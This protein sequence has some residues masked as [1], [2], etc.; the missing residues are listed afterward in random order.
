MQVQFYIPHPLLQ[1]FINCIMIVHA[2]VEADGSSNI[3]IYPPTPQ[4]S[5][6]F[7]INDQVK[8]RKE[9]DA[10]FILQPKSVVVGLQATTVTLDVNKSHKAVRVGFHPGGMYRLLGISMS[11]MIDGSYDAADVF[12][13]EMKE[14]NNT[15]QEADSFDEIKN[16]IESFLL[17]KV[18]ML[19]RA[20]PFDMAMLEML[21]FNGNVTMEKI[22]SLA[23]L[24]L[25]QFE[26]VSKERIGISPKMFARLTRFSKA[27]RLRENFPA[28]SWTNIA[29]EC[30]YF[31]QMHLIRDFKEFAGMTP[32]IIEK[33][34]ETTPIRL[35][36]SMRL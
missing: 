9:G 32:G 22:A 29:Y 33:E 30:G 11:E 14:I 3:C 25:R 26:R 21:R 6:F 5:L 18:N 19:Q 4:T 13:N 2:E 34:L 27:Y 20:L 15:L 17:K 1:Q 7:Y 12:G 35:Q 8:V 24:S 16:I 10:A 23:C 31:D 36:A 28:I